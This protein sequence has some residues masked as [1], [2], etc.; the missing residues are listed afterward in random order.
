MNLKSLVA[1]LAEFEQRY[2]V[3]GKHSIAASGAPLK[4]HFAAPEFPADYRRMTHSL[5]IA[6]RRHY[7][8]ELVNRLEELVIAGHQS[9]YARDTSGFRPVRFLTVGFPSAVRRNWRLVL[10]SAALFFG[11]LIAM[12]LLVVWRPT[13]AYFWVDG[14]VLDSAAEMYLDLEHGGFAGGNFGQSSAARGADT[15]LF[16]WAFYIWNNISIDFRTFAWGIFFGIGAVFMMLYNGL[17]IGVITGHV[18]NAGAS[19]SFFTF[20]CT[21]GAPELIGAVVAGAAGM[22][23]GFALLLPGNWRRMRAVSLAA[24]DAFQLL[25]GPYR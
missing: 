10:F 11:P 1:T 18:I 23:L 19:H 20:T 15:D 21:H 6:R 5:A 4:Y 3:K 24:K 9:F 25:L 16:M 2:T 13:L 22:R 17:T 8:A 14:Q 7:P 12:P